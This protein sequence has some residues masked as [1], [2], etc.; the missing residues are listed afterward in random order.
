MHSLTQLSRIYL[1][2]FKL[3]WLKQ[4]QYRTETLIWLVSQ[5]LEPVIL[6]IV[7]TT[8]ARQ[9]GGAIDGIALSTLVTYFLA[10]LLVTSITSSA[11]MWEYEYR[12]QNGTLSQ[13]LLR[14]L[15]P[16]H[17]DFA[18]CLANKALT[19]LII[20]PTLVGLA[21][22]FHP[23]LHITLWSGVA[24]LLALCIAFV[25]RFLIEWVLALAAF[26]TTRITAVNALYFSI[27]LLFSGEIAPLALL[28]P[29]LRILATLLPFRWVVAFP[30]E[31]LLNIHTPSS[32]LV[33]LAMQIFWLACFL[34]LLI[35][36][37]HLGLRKYAGVGT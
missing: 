13:M 18:E 3:S 5:V 12:V 20:L 29:P 32:T 27:L 1:A 4:M 30:I 35:L 7:W 31:T 14:P 37:W 6:L 28:P 36:V 22:I 23:V 8:V 25:L 15:H 11:I 26:W 24:F 10:E 33:G 2:H 17:A 19:A 16:I 34:G 21:L 9:Q